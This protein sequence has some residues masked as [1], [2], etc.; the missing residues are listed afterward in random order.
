[1]AAERVE[2][3]ERIARIYDASADYD[4]VLTGYAWRLIEPR[5]AGRERVLELGCSNGVM[6]ELLAGVVPD[7]W[8]VDGSPTYLGE[9]RSRLGDDGIRYELSLFE[10]FEPGV[11]FDAIVMC[12]A[13]E[14]LPDPRGTLAR[15]GRWLAPAGELHVMVPNAL[16]LHRL[17]GVALGQ[18]PRPD[19]L[20]ERDLR[21]GHLRV[22]DPD[23][24]RAE[25]EGAGL[26]VVEEAGNSLKFLPNHEMA[27][28]P[29]EYSAA[30]YEVGRCL[31]RH[32]AELYV[33]CV[34][35][36]SGG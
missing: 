5:L 31:P 4:G 19:A 17:I 32:C 35:D 26:R 34:G 12:R 22:Y 36:R 23:A 11:E 6:T 13:L 24:L 28:F 21:V 29:A 27:A 16:S 30:L 20:N 2:Q 9:V 3:L 18:L 8:V 25:L 15:I 1:M 14:H 10:D 33:R 7:L